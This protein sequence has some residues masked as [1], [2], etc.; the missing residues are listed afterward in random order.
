[1]FR[2]NRIVGTVVA[3][4]MIGGAATAQVLSIATPPQ[5]TSTNAAGAAIAKVLSENTD[6][7][8]RVAPT[9]GPN[10]TIPMVNGGELEMVISHAIPIVAAAGGKLM[11][12]GK[13]QP[14]LRLVGAF[15]G[16]PTAMMVRADSEYWEIADLKGARVSSD[17]V[18]QKVVAVLTNASLRMA[19]L[20]M[21]DVNGIPASNTGTAAD[22]LVAGKA[23][24]HLNAMISGKSKQVH[25]SVGIRWLPVPDTDQARE[26]AASLGLVLKT[27]APGPRYPGMDK[28]TLV[29]VGPNL[30]AVSANVPEEVVYEITKVLHTNQE[31]LAAALGAFKGFDPDDMAPDLPIKY[32][33]GSAKYFREVGLKK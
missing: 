14:N 15:H 26:V 2:I 3:A 33:P 32:H 25:A 9:G 20:T 23:D 1:M 18:S 8:M 27:L 31:S 4:V 17:F 12:K 5:G 19:G 28:P 29:A 13:P 21:A 22:D 30:L 6:L 11:F 10:I 24:A 16:L 7:K